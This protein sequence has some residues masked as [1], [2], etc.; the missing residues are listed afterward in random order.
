MP[1][2]TL[3]DQADFFDRYTKDDAEF[4]LLS[5]PKGDEIRSI[6]GHVTESESEKERNQRATEKTSEREAGK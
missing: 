5:S 2:E 6:D 3:P 4:K 1:V